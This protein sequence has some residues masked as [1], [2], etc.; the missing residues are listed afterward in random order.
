MGFGDWLSD[1][2][3][4]IALAPVTGGASLLGGK[5]GIAGGI[6]KILGANNPTQY[7][8]GGYDFLN[9]TLQGQI[10]GEG[11]NLAE[12]QLELA[13]GRLGQQGA[14]GVAGAK[15]ISP[16]LK[17]QMVLDQQGKL[18][19]SLGAQSGLLRMQQQLA[20]QQQLAEL[21]R[22]SMGVNAGA[23]AQNAQLNAGLIGGIMNG[24]GAALGM[25]EGGQVPHMDA[26]GYAWSPS[27]PGGLA[28]Q[29]LYGLLD[30]LGPVG[31]G[32]SEPAQVQMPADAGLM[33]P[34]QG[35]P[36]PEPVSLDRLANN[37]G[38]SPMGQAKKKGGAPGG[39]SGMGDSMPAFQRGVAS[40]RMLAEGGQVPKSIQ[41]FDAWRPPEYPLPEAGQLGYEGETAKKERAKKEAAKKAAPSMAQSKARGGPVF[42][43]DGSVPGRASV[44]G[45]SY[46]N[47]TVEAVLSPGEIVIPRSIAQSPNAPDEARAFVE[48]LMRQKG[49]GFSKVAKARSRLAEGGEA[50]DGG[51]A[52]V[53]V[54]GGFG[55]QEEAD[56]GLREAGWLSQAQRES[57]LEAAMARAHYEAVM[58]AMRGMMEEPSRMFLAPPPPTVSGY[59]GTVKVAPNVYRVGIQ[60]KAEGGEIEKEAKAKSK[61]G[62]NSSWDPFTALDNIHEGAGAFVHSLVRRAMKGAEQ[63]DQG[64]GQVE[65]ARRVVKAKEEAGKAASEANR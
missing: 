61:E 47:D 25:A 26:G 51:E 50:K 22:S 45:D 63:G 36:L 46:Q 14:A 54:S 6:N 15:G 7:D 28:E 16:G 10:R 31:P 57:Y 13:A 32:V 41:E 53:E 3:G 29:N 40:T 39:Q 33:M 64:E 55:G 65:S 24:A 43:S 35:I 11:P 9:N 56:R 17:Q 19:S 38:P 58:S 44:P 18:G 12:K 52:D 42:M 4:G 27:I 34:Q 30:T 48:H 62:P 8:T 5:G 23:A 37:M 49:A 2:I 59:T 60:G 21:L 20:A 1:N